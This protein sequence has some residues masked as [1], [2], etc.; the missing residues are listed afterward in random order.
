[1]T[2]VGAEIDRPAEIVECLALHVYPDRQYNTVTLN[3]NVME[4][5]CLNHKT[6]DTMRLSDKL[7]PESKSGSTSTDNEVQVLVV[8][9]QRCDVPTLCR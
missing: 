2:D 7:Q 1:M 6:Q 3:C 5:H 8:L 4:W 9:D